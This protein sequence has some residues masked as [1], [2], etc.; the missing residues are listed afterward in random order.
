LN[1]KSIHQVNF[2][3]VQVQHTNCKS[4]CNFEL[5]YPHYNYPHHITTEW[6]PAFTA[7]SVILGISWLQERT[8]PTKN[9]LERRNQE[10]MRITW[11][12]AQSAAVNRQERRRSVTECLHLDAG[13]FTISR[14]WPGHL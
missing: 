3:P 9:K 12:E 6:P 8:R 13:W 11:E 14:F 7:T 1:V 2:S 10:K 5:Q 4:N